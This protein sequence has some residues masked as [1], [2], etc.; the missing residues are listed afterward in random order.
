MPV[1]PGDPLTTVTGLPLGAEDDAGDE[2]DDELLLDDEPPEHAAPSTA[3]TT[4]TIPSRIR[5]AAPYETVVRKVCVGP[6]GST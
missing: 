4:P 1:A 5:M 2:G 6:E 3:R